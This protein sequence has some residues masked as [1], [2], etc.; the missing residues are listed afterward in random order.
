MQ[1]QLEAMQKKLADSEMKLRE[2]KLSVERQSNEIHAEKLKIEQEKSWLASQREDLS[3]RSHKLEND[4][5]VREKQAARLEMAQKLLIESEKEMQRLAAELDAREESLRLRQDELR[6]EKSSTTPINYPFPPYKAFDE[7]EK[8]LDATNRNFLETE[9]R[10][11]DSDLQALVELK[12][13]LAMHQVNE[14]SSRSRALDAKEAELRREME[15]ERMDLQK[16][17]HKIKMEREQLEVTRKVLHEEEMELRLQQQ[18]LAEGSKDTRLAQERIK[19]LAVQMKQKDED[20]RRDRDALEQRLKKCDECEGFL[21]AWQ[22]QLDQTAAA[23]QAR[24]RELIF[25]EKPL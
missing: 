20:M 15:D 18:K 4:T 21:T 11:I 13:Q 2:E 19:Q 7:R 6:V 22:Q 23:I 12:S 8:S 25:N 24:E 1:D 3:L 16:T 9:R 5:L 14:I 10:Q 17:L